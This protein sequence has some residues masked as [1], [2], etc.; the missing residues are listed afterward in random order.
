[1]SRPSEGVVEVR[2][3]PSEGDQMLAYLIGQGPLQRENR[4]GGA[5]VEIVQIQQ[6]GQLVG[7]DAVVIDAQVGQNTAVVVPGARGYG[8]QGGRL[9]S[10]FVPAGVVGGQ[11]CPHQPGSQAQVGVLEP[12][13]LHVQDDPLA[14]QDVALDGVAA[15]LVPA[16]PAP[17]PVHAV[18][19]GEGALVCGSNDAELT[20]LTSL[21]QR[22]E[23]CNCVSS[24]RASR[25]Q[26]QSVP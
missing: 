1:M 9:A 2:L 15:V 14:H 18:P 21:V 17:G 4:L 7:R 10:S 6:P 5:E 19:S 12:R 16:A 13:P 25:Q 20:V 22:G 26:G 23:P 24:G 3:G 8:I 11:Q